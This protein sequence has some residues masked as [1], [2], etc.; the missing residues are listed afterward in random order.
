[1]QPRS[2]AAQQKRCRDIRRFTEESVSSPRLKAQLLACLSAYQRVL[3]EGWT[4]QSITPEI[5]L[6]MT[7]IERELESLHNEARLH[8]H[9]S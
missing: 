8:A 3:A 7:S 6:R 5:G 4:A 2:L 9:P 1:M